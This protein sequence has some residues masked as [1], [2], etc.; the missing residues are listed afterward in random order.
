[1][2]I[3]STK[4]IV[5]DVWSMF[6]DDKVIIAGCFDQIVSPY[7]GIWD[8]TTYKLITTLEGHT[9]WVK[10]IHASDDIIVTGSDDTTIK[11]WDRT[12][13]ELIKTIDNRS[14]KTGVLNLFL[15]QIHPS[16]LGH[17]EKSR[18]GTAKRM[19]ALYL[20]VLVG[21]IQLLSST[22]SFGLVCQTVL[23]KF[24]IFQLIH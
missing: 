14:E 16:Y 22:I 23:C 20:K 11:I 4:T 1:M 10:S 3:I 17:M 13:Y 8:R 6:V 18:S 12:T 7:S 9:D 19:N 21:F 2:H 24:G 15:Q 5:A